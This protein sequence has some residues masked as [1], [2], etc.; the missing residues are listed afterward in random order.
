MQNNFEEK[1]RLKGHMGPRRLHLAKKEIQISLN[2]KKKEK[3]KGNKKEEEKGTKRE[4]K[5]EKRNFR[6]H[7]NKARAGNVALLLGKR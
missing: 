5:R 3:K 7:R 1:H 4:K 6:C 2:M